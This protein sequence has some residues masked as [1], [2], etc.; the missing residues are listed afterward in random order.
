MNETIPVIDPPREIPTINNGVY[1][2]GA[3]TDLARFIILLVGIWYGLYGK[4]YTKINR[5]PLCALAYAGH[6][7]LELE[8]HKEIEQ[9]Y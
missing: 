1:G 3:V 5:F 2:Q 6:F 4:K 8:S 7:W 9:N